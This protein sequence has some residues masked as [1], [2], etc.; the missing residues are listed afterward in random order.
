M[1]DFPNND[2]G[3]FVILSDKVF[4]AGILTSGSAIETEFR[5][6]NEGKEDIKIQRVLPSCTCTNVEVTPSVVPPGGH[7]VINMTIDPSKTS[8]EK[9]SVS[10]ETSGGTERVHAVWSKVMSLRA[11]PSSVFIP[12]V[13]IGESGSANATILGLPSD[14]DYF[15]STIALVG[16]R[17]VTK[18][19]HSARIEK[20]AIQFLVDS[21]ESIQGGQFAG[22]INI[23]RS[24]TDTPVLTIPWSVNLK[25]ATEVFPTNPAFRSESGL[26]C[27]QLIIVSSETATATDINIVPTDTVDTCDYVIYPT[28]DKDTYIADISF[29][30]AH[31]PSGCWVTTKKSKCRVEFRRT[32]ISEASDGI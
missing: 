7:G 11:I 14:V 29:S 20:G 27:T 21:D 30:N 10:I 13:I 18:L 12:S 32:V 8:S 6:K 17:E 28:P 2:G 16:G 22:I 9:A 25:R 1:K 24:G 5:F 19:R 23:L 26:S 31:I 15:C 4:N 3:S